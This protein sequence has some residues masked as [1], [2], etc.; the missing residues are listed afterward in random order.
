MQI[1]MRTLVCL[2]VVAL[3]DA[4]LYAGAFSL[5][6]ESSAVAIGN[7]AA[8]IAAEGYDAS[9]G[10]Y[11]PAGLVLI[12]DQQ[13]LLGGVGV[14]PSA[15]LTGTSTYSTRNEAGGDPFP[16]YIESFTSLQG[17]KKAIVPS[18][19]YAQPL[20][21]RAVFG[22]SIVS[23]F[24]LSTDYDLSS[25]VRYA[26][27][28]SQLQTLNLSPELGGKLTDNLSIGGGIDF[29]YANVKF[30][31]MLGSPSLIPSLGLFSPTIFDS[32]SYNT[33]DSFAVGFHAGL[34]F[35]F[36]DEHTRWGLNY[37][38]HMNHQFT[39]HSILTG[40]LADTTASFSF[41]DEINNPKATF[42]SDNLT[43]NYISLPNIV[44]LSAY[45]DLTNQWALLGSIVFSGWSSFQSIQLN[46][47][48][49]YSINQETDFLVPAQANSTTPEDY[50]DTW[51]F[52]L[53]ANYRVND[54]WLIRMGGGYDQTPTVYPERDVRLPDANRWALSIGTHYQM[55]Y[56]LGLDAGFT[57]LFANSTADINNTTPIGALS[58]YN[59]NAAAKVNAKLI[60]LQVV[61]LM[62]AK[63][64]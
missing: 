5:Y 15:K 61:W 28:W 31:R 48:A 6:T 13:V 51:R 64:P 4:P 59:V 14:L 57:Y 33:G 53:G 7:Y 44:T 9:I 52:A 47:I 1:P 35:M 24:G 54:Q 39:G 46:N 10:W 36:N 2:S 41:P 3:M 38:S 49:A 32:Q 22:L 12:K 60:G 20:G 21:E 11:N 56:N 37:Q 34:M 45:Q 58:T 18:F 50:R 23:P 30:N 26:A 63:K 40:P 17:A 62:D 27:T 55:L 16:P 29:Q 25:P 19:H 8:G 43:S 42:T